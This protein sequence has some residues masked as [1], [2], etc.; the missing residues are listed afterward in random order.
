MTSL[1]VP[2]GLIQ[3]L[4][5]TK[6]TQCIVKDKLV[7]GTEDGIL[8]VDWQHN[9]EPRQ[10]LIGPCGNIIFLLP[11][12]VESD[13]VQQGLLSV[14]D[15]GEIS[16]WDLEDGRCIVSRNQ[17]V[18][19]VQHLILS[20]EWLF[21]YGDSNV[22]QLLNTSSLETR[23]TFEFPNWISSVQVIQSDLVVLDWDGLLQ[24]YKID[25]DQLTLTKKTELL[26]KK[27][28]IDG[29]LVV[30][31]FDHNIVL[32]CGSDGLQIFRIDK[33]IH[34]LLE[35]EG[36]FENA[37]FLSART[38]LVHDKH[39]Q[40]Y[41]YY[42][43]QESDF[44][45]DIISQIPQHAIILASDGHY[46]CYVDQLSIGNYSNYKYVTLLAKTPKQ[47][48][49][50]FIAY[51]PPD[52][53]NDLQQHL[54][55]VKQDYFDQ[56]QVQVCRFWAS[57]F[58]SNVQPSVTQNTFPIV[59]QADPPKQI[60]KIPNAFQPVFTA[61]ISIARTHAALGQADGTVLIVPLQYLLSGFDPQ[62]K[63]VQRLDDDCS[64]P[65]TA[66]SVP[67]YSVDH[68]KRHLLVG[69]EN[70]TVTLWDTDK[71]ERISTFGCHA[72]AVFQFL[73]VPVQI[74]GKLRSSSLSI[75][76]DNTIAVIN[77]EDGTK[78]L[79]F[80]G[81]TPIDGV[82][83]RVQDHIMLVHLRDGRLFVWQLK[84]GHLDRIVTGP[85]VRDMIQSCSEYKSKLD[86]NILESVNFKRTLS[87][88]CISRPK[89][90]PSVGVL[91]LNLKRLID[92]IYNGEHLLSP[93]LTRRTQSREEQKR[94]RKE[95]KQE[96]KDP[97]EFLKKTFQ[98][99]KEEETPQTP[100]TPA[101]SRSIESDKRRGPPNTNVTHAILSALLSWG[102]DPM[103]DEQCIKNFGLVPCAGF[104]SV[105]YRGANG[106]LNFPL[107]YRKQP[108]DDWS[109]SAYSSAQRLL[110][111][112]SL[113]KCVMST[114]GLE[115][116]AIQ[117]ITH[118]GVTVPDSSA[119]YKPASLSY[120]IRYWQDPIADVG[121]AARSIFETTLK[122]MTPEQKQT[123]IQYHKDFL[124]V[125]KTNRQKQSLRACMI[126][127]LVHV[128]DPQ[129]IPTRLSKDISSSLDTIIRE[130]VKSP[131]RLLA[132]EL[133]GLG[134]SYWEPH[135]NG[136]SM[137]RL[138]VSLTGLHQTQLQLTP[139][140]MMQARTTLQAIVGFNAPL[141]INTLL[142]DLL[143]S[144]SIGERISSLK[145][146]GSLVSKK[147]LLLYQ[148]VPSM[149]D[150]MVKTLD[151]NNPQLRE[152]LQ[153]LITVN[154]AELVTLSCVDFHAGSQKLVVGLLDGSI[155]IYD[156][157]TAT[158]FMVIQTADPVHCV[159]YSPNGKLLGTL[160][161]TQNTVSFWQPHGGLLNTLV[162]L[163]HSANPLKP[164]RTFPLGPKPEQ[165][166]LQEVVGQVKF[167][168]L[169][170]RSAKIQ[171]LG[172]ELVF[173]V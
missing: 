66:L 156:L 148:Y 22:L 61:I 47:D 93:I 151:P 114:Q 36:S 112:L 77:I 79:F 155:V 32:H 121:Q 87:V 45:Q 2:I 125:L 41:V 154:I 14:S 90:M 13:Q 23:Q 120:I 71:F 76:L 86:W 83:W 18:E 157:R 27:P 68:S 51:V 16:L 17:G 109:V 89:E 69:H 173:N 33:E 26:L 15:E 59:L 42:L 57:L 118:Y 5:K 37:Y 60:E 35:V 82:Y 99:K 111:I 160:S 170:D 20:G 162:Q 130:E 63:M 123:L 122:K 58:C 9:L 158:R 146:L 70:G 97:M 74:G 92:E 104:V 168:W 119:E 10:Y 147:P 141:V 133:L 169:G 166:T 54:V 28:L 172:L 72:D 29:Q 80:S 159:S 131:F 21:G 73:P 164:F 25:F 153:D 140:A 62:D 75:G 85:I 56:T 40:A 30:N 142:F 100:G 124:P 103:V 81:H 84:T 165:V 106:Y 43:G 102:L 4:P 38:F 108:S 136:A 64:F 167:Q 110:S 149:V 6:I 143:H 95:D 7:C 152:S 101:E 44:K 52:P 50:Y 65:V 161:L 46:A 31:D 139:P 129:L 91:Q 39:A 12:K 150:A 132:I 134:F 145:I 98:L 11:C 1:S 127:A 24:I 53:K 117:L 137:L 19:N 34:V 55:M 107:S 144:K 96:K 116:Q 138:L 135:I 163:S 171:S 88:Y 126:L 8:L 78:T 48:G 113:M 49:R 105:G 115:E 67:E 128:Y 94:E 3:S